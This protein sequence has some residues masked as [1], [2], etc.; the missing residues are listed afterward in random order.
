MK[1]KACQ[2]I[3][4]KSVDLSQEENNN[5]EAQK[6]RKT[7]VRN[8]NLIIIVTAFYV[9]YCF[10]PNSLS[11]AIAQ[12]CRSS[13]KVI[14]YANSTRAMCF[15]ISFFYPPVNFYFILSEIFSPQFLEFFNLCKLTKLNSVSFNIFF[16]CTSY[17]FCFKSARN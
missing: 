8:M 10:L 3:S 12:K 15:S 2:Q 13:L 7:L 6:K 11:L 1:I 16:F 9:P 14:Y 5:N 4:N 17:N